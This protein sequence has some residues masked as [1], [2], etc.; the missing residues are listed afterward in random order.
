MDAII[1][2]A[3]LRFRPIM[4]NRGRSHPRHAPPH[5]QYLLGPH[6]RRHRGRPHRCNRADPARAARHVCSRVS[7]EGV[8]ANISK[9]ANLFL[10]KLNRKEV[11]AYTQ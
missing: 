8:E 11:L 5:A 4:L 9:N 3:I 7:G 2:S 10:E 1:D 6:G